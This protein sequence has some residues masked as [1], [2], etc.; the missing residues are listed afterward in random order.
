VL[1]GGDVGVL[2]QMHS[3]APGARA[4]GFSGVLPRDPKHPD[5]RDRALVRA[6][7]GAVTELVDWNGGWWFAKRIPP[8][9]GQALEKVFKALV[10]RGKEATKT[11]VRARGITILY[12][13]AYPYRFEVTD[14]LEQATEKARK[15]LDYIQAGNDFAVVAKEG[16]PGLPLSG[17][18]DESG[19]RGGVLLAFD[20][21]GKG[22]AW[23]SRFDSGYP[24]KLMEV[25][26]QAPV[27]LVP[28]PIVTARGV[29]VVELLERREVTPR[30]L[31]L[32]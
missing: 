16:V 4:D 30:D 7:V 21:P 32:R 28:D 6:R 14:T 20:E 11:R 5:E 17:S 13:G 22:D 19:N 8:A 24:D 9:T 3:N 12:V 29:M 31:N 27:G 10:Q 25:L 18:W 15:I 2:A 1:K 26:F 23:I